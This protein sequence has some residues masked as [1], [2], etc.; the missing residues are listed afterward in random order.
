MIITEKDIRQ[1]VTKELQDKEDLLWASPI[2]VNL[3]NKWISEQTKFSV[4]TAMFAFL[5]ALFLL[6]LIFQQVNSNKE[7]INVGAIIMLSGF[8]IFIVYGTIMSFPRFNLPIQ[9]ELLRPVFGYALSTSRIFF[10]G[11]DKEIVSIYPTS[12][13]SKAGL[14]RQLSNKFKWENRALVIWVKPRFSFKSIELYFL[15]N[16]KPVITQIN[17]ALKEPNNE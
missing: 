3:R 14:Y 10:L 15:P 1:A 16:F 2:D 17:A 6:F 11:Q 4:F 12:I 13:L 8:T 5:F 9:Y 7:E